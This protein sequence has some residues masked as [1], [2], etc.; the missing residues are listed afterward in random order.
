MKPSFRVCAWV[1]AVVVT[2]LLSTSF[3]TASDG[4]GEIHQACVATGCLAGDTAGFPIQITQPGSYLLT[5]NLTVPDENTTAIE[6]TAEGPVQIDLGGFSISGVTTC[7][8]NPIVCTPLGTGSGINSDPSRSISIRNGAIRGMGG[9]AIN[10]GSGLIED[11]V[12]RGNGGTGIAAAAAIVQSNVVIGNGSTGITNGAGMILNNQVFGNGGTGIAGT[13]GPTVRGNR[14]RGNGGAGNNPGIRTVDG[15]V[16]DNH[17][18]LNDS[19]GL[20]A[21]G[22]TVFGNNVFRSNNLPANAGNQVAGGTQIGLNLCQNV[23]CP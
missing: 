11:T 13:V 14:V 10:V 21:N 15:Y 23:P 6:V 18:E 16:F 1:L 17:V 2:T 4:V 19:V 8:G 3:A 12:V 9:F 5:S 22:T 20:Q 7:S